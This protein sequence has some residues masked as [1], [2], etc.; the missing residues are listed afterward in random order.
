MKRLLNIARIFL[1]IAILAA[2]IILPLWRSGAFVTDHSA[3]YEGNTLYWNGKRYSPITAEYTEGRTIAKTGD[4]KWVI[5]EVKEDPTH[6]F[7]VV[8]SFL[9]QYLFVADDCQ[10]PAS[11]EV[12][13]I[14]W[15]RTYISDP[16][17][18]N[19]LSTIDATKTTSFEHQTDGIY[20][21][22]D[23]QRMKPLYFAYEGCP[24][25]IDLRGYLGKINGRWVITTYQT[26]AR[27]EDGSP[28]THI[29]GCYLIPEEYHAILQKYNF[30]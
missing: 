7:V 5:N 30:E 12:T 18:L 16:N 27:N 10:V 22:T 14:A 1:C 21:L 19:A 15:N 2:A 23:T 26:P 11:G 3:L 8:R 24:V 6:Q 9:D 28:K 20:I 13:T 17:F 29:V 4:G 25:A